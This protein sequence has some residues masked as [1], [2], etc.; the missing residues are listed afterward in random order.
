VVLSKAKGKVTY[1]TRITLR[2]EGDFEGHGFGKGIDMLLTG[3]DEYGSLNRAAKE[4]GMA[5][6]KAWRVLR[7]TEEEFGVRLIE[8][9][10]AHG[11]TITQEGRDFLLHYREMVR[12]AEEAA[13][14]VFERYFQ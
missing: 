5:Y 9:N 8:R 3:I 10:G 7:L 13:G 11:S 12:A 1:K 4:L 6:S 2:V 14:L